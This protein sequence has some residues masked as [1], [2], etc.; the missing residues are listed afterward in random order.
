[1]LQQ[2]CDQSINFLERLKLPQGKARRQ[3][4][5]SSNFWREA[6][7][8]DRQPLINRLINGINGIM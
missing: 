7:G 3:N 8:F 2:L 5:I 6:E 1:M 4:S